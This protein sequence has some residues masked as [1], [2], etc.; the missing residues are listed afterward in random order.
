MLRKR[1]TTTLLVCTA[2]AGI[3][4]TTGTTVGRSAA[5]AR[6]TGTSSTAA[7][8]TPIK[9]IAILYLENQ[10][11]DS[12]LG[13]WCDNRPARCP[14]GGMPS[15]V[16]LSNGAVVTPRVNPDIVPIVTHNVKSQLAAMNI[17]H[18]MP[19]MNGW[20]NIGA[21][22]CNKASHYRCIS[23]YLPRQEPNLTALATKFAISDATFSLADSPSWGGHLFAI[24]S[25]LD[26]FLGGTP[27]SIRGVP[28]GEGWGCDSNKVTEWAA[29]LGGTVQEVPAC[30]P[31]PALKYKG[32]PLPNGGAFESTPV[33]FEPTILDEL[34]AAG[35]PWTLYTG[36]CRQE[37]IASDGLKMC[38][39]KTADR[40]YGWSMCPS[41]AKCIYTES[42]HF[43]EPD[44]FLTDA[45]AGRLPAFSV[46]TPGG[47]RVGDSEHNGFSM[48]A[49]D[50][51]IGQIAS[52][53]M[54]S[55]E[56][57]STVLFIAWDDCGCFYDQVPPRI[58]PDGTQEGP[59]VPLVIVS[60]YARP[61]FTDSAATT[62]AGI[63]AYTENTFGLR[64][65]GPN[66][67]NV[68]P[69][70]NAFNYS[71]AP[72]RPVPMVH[73]AV[74]PGDHVRWAQAREDT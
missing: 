4:A 52:A 55:P 66:D 19:K 31:D 36:S 28:S 40:S 42:G 33:A 37:V 13:F 29:R 47:N 34:Q 2:I 50:N 62:Y 16:T 30:I 38:E 70:T 39:R 58:N 49:G 21:G 9:H 57:S 26:G 24:T 41:I 54:H 32:A 22:Q 44:K 35:E 11:F 20:Q 56:W 6:L 51:W 73:R 3:T 65:L 43:A 7:L 1:L 18:G 25:N 59:R 15:S 63:L 60:P 61:G 46:I 74:P 64:P 17:Q 12:I 53:V 27:H 71:Q 68:Y 23:G 69:F 72:L 5:E 10:S 45:A 14:L 8:A 48:T 67:A